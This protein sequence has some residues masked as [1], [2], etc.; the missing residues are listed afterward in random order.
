MAL[1]LL[2]S[3]HRAIL[4]ENYLMLLV[5]IE[6]QQFHL[7]RQSS[8]SCLKLY[9]KTQLLSSLLLFFFFFF[10]AGSF[11]SSLSSPSSPSSSSYSPVS[12]EPPFF[13]SS[14]DD[15]GFY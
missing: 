15:F 14:W 7:L 11:S 10:F 3:N 9:F 12:P 2:P 1:Y 6:L 13:S 8:F 4:Y 5:Q